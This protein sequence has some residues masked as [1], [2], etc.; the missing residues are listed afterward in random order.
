MAKV[1]PSKEHDAFAGLVDRLLTVPKADLDAKV[2]A[3]RERAA[4]D[5]HKRG[6]KPRVTSSSDASRD[7]S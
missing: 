5:P 2:K 4:L 3:H 7:V 1:Q 6:P